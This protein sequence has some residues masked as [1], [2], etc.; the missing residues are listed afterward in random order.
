[1]ICDLVIE[2][3]VSADNIFKPCPVLWGFY[4]FFATFYGKKTNW[5]F[6]TMSLEELEIFNP[7]R[8]GVG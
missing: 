7:F 3:T 6:A 2:W 1:M 5:E 8:V 4:G